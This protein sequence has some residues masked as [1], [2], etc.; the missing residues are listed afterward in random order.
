MTLN[1]QTNVSEKQ[2]N[3]NPTQTQTQTRFEKILNPNPKPKPCLKKKS[4]PNP[5]PKPI[6][7]K[8]Q[9]QTHVWRSKPTGLHISGTYNEK[10][11]TRIFSAIVHKILLKVANFGLKEIKI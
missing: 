2:S 3:S 6:S 4:N 8:S 10:V 7:K 5:K 11:H 9:T 1:F